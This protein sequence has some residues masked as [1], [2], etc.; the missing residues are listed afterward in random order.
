MAVVVF[1]PTTFRA[2]FPQFTSVTLYPNAQLQMYFDT[3][4]EFIS[5]RDNL[6]A[7]GCGSGSLRPKKLALALNLMTAHL[8]ALG[9]Q[10]AAGETTGLLQS[11][12][13]DKVSVSLTPPPNKNQWQWWLNQTPYGQQLLAL[14]AVASVGGYYFGGNPVLPAFRGFRG[15][16]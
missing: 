15:P 5:N 11:A 16:C 10:A 2:Q 3:A 7:C 14:L 1:D 13:I 4:E 8:A 6:T 9:I 12:T